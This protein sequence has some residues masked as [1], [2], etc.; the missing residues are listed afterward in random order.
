[1]TRPPT[2]SRAQATV[3]MDRQEA[4]VLLAALSELPFKTVYALIGNL[5]AQAY[6]NFS[7]P[8]QHSLR[9]PFEFDR[10]EL[11]FCAT[12]LETLPYRDVHALLG[13][14]HGATGAGGS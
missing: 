14:M 9:K 3:E 2:N 11:A 6:R 13:R 1:V 5:N 4:G 7:D 12:A 8:S 10:Q